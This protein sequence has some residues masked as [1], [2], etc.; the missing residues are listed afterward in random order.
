MLS[1]GKLPLNHNDNLSTALP[2]VVK[3]SPARFEQQSNFFGQGWSLPVV[4]SHIVQKAETEFELTSLT[5]QR[6][7]L[8]RT[9]PDGSAISHPSGWEGVVGHNTVEITDPVGFQYKYEKGALISFKTTSG[10]K[11]FVDRSARNRILLMDS[12]SR[13]TL[14]AVTKSSDGETLQLDFDSR[15]YTVKLGRRPI[16]VGSVRQ[17]SVNRLV[18]AVASINDGNNA[19]YTIDY[20]FSAGL[21]EMEI[22][23]SEGIKEQ[24][25]WNPANNIL[26]K[27]NENSFLVVANK[28]GEL[29][30]IS[31]ITE[32]KNITEKFHHGLDKS[33]RSISVNGVIKTTTTFTYG[34]GFQSP[35]KVT[36][37]V[38]G[39]S[40]DLYRSSIDELGRCLKETFLGEDAIF[41]DASYQYETEIDQHTKKLSNNGVTQQVWS[42]EKTKL[43]KILTPFWV[44]TMKDDGRLSFRKNEEEG[45]FQ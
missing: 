35:R 18:P 26:V 41:T 37:E 2:V 17:A 42:Y 30:T 8:S 40:I 4:S 22:S 16:I 5:G 34:L 3:F 32:N 7:G 38:G 36:S 21:A 39:K 14:L 31:R 33:F 25:V 11:V 27:Q 9:T 6:I 1:L 13:K 10:R 29:P 44:L 19:L 28:V 23:N 12:A 24:L 45:S 20:G 15:R 43:K